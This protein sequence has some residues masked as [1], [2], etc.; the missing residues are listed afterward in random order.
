MSS[1]KG[2]PLHFFAKDTISGLYSSQLPAHI[3]ALDQAY[4]ITAD[5]KSVRHEVNEPKQKGQEDNKEKEEE[6][7]EEEEES[8]ET[9]ED[10]LTEAEPTLDP[11]LEIIENAAATGEELESEGGEG[12]ALAHDPSE[13]DVFGEGNDLDI[14]SATPL[15]LA[16][17]GDDELINEF[18][19]ETVAKDTNLTPVSNPPNGPL[20][21]IPPIFTGTDSFNSVGNTLLNVSNTMVENFNF[22]IPFQLQLQLQ[23]QKISLIDNSLH[24][25]RDPFDVPA[26]N[27]VGS[28]LA[29]DQGL[30]LMVT[31]LQNVTNGAFV[32]M[33]ADGTFKYVPPPGFSDTTDSFEYI[34]QDLNG[35]ISTG[36]VNIVLSDTVWYVDNTDIATGN[37]GTGT[38]LDPFS[39]LDI[40]W[41]DDRPDNPGDTIFIRTGIGLYA[42]GDGKQDLQ[43]LMNQNLVGE[44]VALLVDDILLWNQGPAPSL[45]GN[46]FITL[47]DTS[48]I[49]LIPRNT[50]ILLLD[51]PE[52][53]IEFV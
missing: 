1:E 37:L 32:Q 9:E 38:A 31:G 40:F 5:G 26:V 47:A 18:F 7:E 20:P 33:E 50:T 2:T 16:F 43:L 27:I 23:P 22:V 4:S 51:L 8:E 11:N 25:P 15:L 30:G 39:S 45:E 3:V 52:P 46:D 29:N 13:G 49:N 44:G 10:E 14:D 34:V 12:V 24:N 6:G 42:S 19:L 21:N 36:Q 35:N 41:G 28:V 48:G 53:S 17:F